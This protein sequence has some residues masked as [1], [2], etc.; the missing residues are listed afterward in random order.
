MKKKPIITIVIILLAFAG[1]IFTNFKGVDG[2][3]LYSANDIKLGLDLAGGVSITYEAEGSPSAQDMKDTVEKLKKRVESYSV[4]SEV[5]R[6]GENR[7]N[8]EIPGIQDVNRVLS[9]LGQPGNLSFKSEEAMAIMQKK[10]MAQVQKQLKNAKTEEE[11]KQYE[12]LEPKMSDEEIEAALNAEE[13]PD[14]LTG[15][16]VTAAKAVT[17]EDRSTGG[18]QNDVVLSL[19]EEGTKR[20]AEFTKNNIGKKL[21]IIYDNQVVSAPV[22]QTEIPGGEVS[23]TGQK[24]FEEAEEL[25][26]TIRIG[27]LPT[28]L[29]EI[30]SNV[31]GA[32]LGQEAIDTSLKAGLIGLILVIIFMIIVYRWAGLLGSVALTLYSSLM[33]F[34]ISAFRLTLTLEGIAGIILSIG[35]AIDAN[36]IIFTRIKEEIGKGQSVEKSIDNGFKKAL[37]AIVDGNITTLIAA[38]VLWAMGSGSIKGFAQTLTLGILLSMFTS[39]LITKLLVK[40]FYRVGMRK[41]VL[42]GKIAPRKRILDILKLRWMF[43]GVSAAIIIAGFGFMAKNNADEGRVLNYSLEFSGGTLTHITLKED[44]SLQDL[45]NKLKPEIAAITGDNDIHAQKVRDTNEVLIKTRNL[46][47]EERKSLES[48]FMKDFSVDKENITHEN[49]SSTISGEMRRKAVTSG[50]IAGILMLLYIWFRFKNVRFGASSVIALVHDCLIILAFYAISK[51]S[52]G[53]AFIA[54]ILT[55]IGYSI[56]ATIVVFDRIRE[57]LAE[58]RNLSPK[59]IVNKSITQTL[60]RCIYTSLTVV[61]MTAMLYFLGVESMKDFALPLLVGIVGGTWSSIGISGALYYLFFNKIKAKKA[62]VKSKN[63]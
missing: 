4:E 61:F 7:I 3:G 37:S 9:E 15:I 48:M 27:A 44:M 55:I 30:R 10:G 50:I 11:K 12:A 63:K 8:V 42:Y 2:Q 29:T 43:I 62:A 22:V 26:T 17:H 25:A 1:L 49:I 40:S 38:A 5:Y 60:S 57:N 21:Y 45:D 20:F 46:T 13:K 35:M 56:N 6:E 28:Q 59:E 23:I 41:E 32:K 16:D 53:N 51:I 14:V 34:L 18:K 31:V 39:L 58:E 33:V 24:S 54:V 36:I 47:L 19:S 52:V